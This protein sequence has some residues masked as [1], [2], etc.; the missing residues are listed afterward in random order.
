MSGKALGLQL[1]TNGFGVCAS[2]K[3]SKPLF[4]DFNKV[5]FDAQFIKDQEEIKVQNTRLPNP[6]P[7]VVQKVNSA[8][9]IRISYEIG[10]Y[11]SKEKPNKPL[12]S[13]SAISGINLGILKPYYVT[14]EDPLDDNSGLQVIQQGEKTK[15]FSENI[16]GPAKWTEGL[17]ESTTSYGFHVAA[18]INFEWNHS[19]Y[20]QSWD[21][22]IRLDYFPN[23]LNILYNSENQIFTSLYTA[24]SIGKK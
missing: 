15:A 18:N 6:K 24:Y 11:I 21:C 3:I 22:G 13:V 1:A 17:E 4:S 16:Y 9:T 2:S 14:F 12:L 7:Y 23:G 10:Q 5:R 19:F 8:G 20:F